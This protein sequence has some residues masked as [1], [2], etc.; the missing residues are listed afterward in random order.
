MSIATP[1][2]PVLPVARLT[3][4][5]FTNADGNKLFEALRAALTEQAGPVT[6]DLTD[7]ISFSSSFL[8]SSLSPLADDLGTASYQRLRL[9][10]YKPAHLKQLKDY[11]AT[12]AQPAA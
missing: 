3:A 8:N 5:T 11:L 7:V 10:N 9:R 4:G 2:H 1:T 6:L 12:V